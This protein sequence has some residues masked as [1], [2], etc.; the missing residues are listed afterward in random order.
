MLV[1]HAG[2][3]GDTLPFY[4]KHCTEVRLDIEPRTNPDIVGDMAHLPENIG[5]F[6]A[7]FSAHALEHLSPHDVGPCLKGFFRVLK[8]GGK[9]M[10]W[11]PDLEG[12]SP[13]FDILY[14]SD[15]GPV[16]GF[17]MFYGHMAQ[18]KGFPYMLHRCGFVQSTLRSAIEGAGFIDV[19]IERIN[20]EGSHPQ[21]LF[22]FGVKP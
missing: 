10:V 9:L 5:P 12:I 13:T 21:N 18:S 17:D 2:C 14:E 8:P 15:G 6:D 16:T 20:H 3:G 22:G 4:L 19:K 1:L 11:V 7:V